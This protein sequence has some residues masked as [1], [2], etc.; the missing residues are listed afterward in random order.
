MLH[1]RCKIQRGKR[2]ISDK[3]VM[4]ANTKVLAIPSPSGP[5]VFKAHNDPEG[6]LWCILQGIWKAD[7]RHCAHSITS[8]I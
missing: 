2:E 8:R 4:E 6:N 5:H 1:G 3:L 7:A